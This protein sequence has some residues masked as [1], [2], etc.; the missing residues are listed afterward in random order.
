MKI[1]YIC[2][3]FNN[4]H[5]TADA[6]RSLVNSAGNLHELRVIVVDNL[7]TQE[8][9][10]ILKRIVCEFPC[11]DLLLND[12]NVGYFP[13]L[14]CG[15]RRVREQYPDVKHLVIGNNDLV[16][17]S[18]FFTNLESQ[19]VLL[20]TYPVVAP[21]ITTLDG[22]YQNPHVIKAISKTRE[23]IYDVYYS[24]YYLAQIILR[25]ANATQ[26]LTR[27]RDSLQHTKAQLISQGHGS[28]YLIG[29]KFF[30]HFQ[31]LWAPTFLMGEEFFLGKQLADQG[32][33]TYYA[34]EVKLTHCCHGSLSS[35]P[36]RK[37]WQ[38]AREAHLEYRKYV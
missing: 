15:I 12:T 3:N 5:F 24:N 30:Q 14:N 19:L 4:S 38:L 17:P 32:M 20:E 13:G 34:P 33:Q 9:R 26:W 36:S 31:E 11:V 37:I 23:L 16:F 35:V 21:N 27:R 7:S 10:D 25:V 2:T 6:V 22:E 8:Q 29:P 1:G 18:D 28:C